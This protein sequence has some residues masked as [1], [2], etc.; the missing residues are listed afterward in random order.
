MD[1]EKTKPGTVKYS[2]ARPK[3]QRMPVHVLNNPAPATQAVYVRHLENPPVSATQQV[4][5]QYFENPTSGPIQLA[6]G[7]LNVVSAPEA[8]PANVFDK[9]NTD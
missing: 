2:T 6:V 1:E 9:S 3:P 4:F 5:V 8:T 7:V